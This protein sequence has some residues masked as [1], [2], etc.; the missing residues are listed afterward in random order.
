MSEAHENSGSNNGKPADTLT[1]EKY[2]SYLAALLDGQRRPCQTT[3]DDVLERN[4]P[5]RAL[6]EDVFQRSLYEVGE[7]WERG[8]I[9]VADEHLATAM[10][11]SL[12]TRVYPALFDAPHIGRT[13]IVSC[14]AN[15][16][17]QIGGKMAADTFELHGWDSYF[18]GANTPINELLA[19]V[20]KKKPDVVALSMTIY[21]GMPKLLETVEALCSRY[22]DLQIWVGGQ[23]FSWGGTKLLSAY[24]QVHLL[25]SLTDLENRLAEW[26]ENK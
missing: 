18:L 26:K 7:K 13:A 9:S 14:I 20:E 16:F 11:E 2:K 25:E 8:Q 24:K 19:L 17:H 15:E 12:L 23:A 22:D 10:T 5:I 3:V 6:Y 21:S 1:E 4:R